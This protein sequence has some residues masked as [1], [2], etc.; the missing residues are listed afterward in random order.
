MMDLNYRKVFRVLFFLACLS[1][2]LWQCYL[3]MD[4]FLER[5]RST[6]VGFDHAKNWPMPRFVICPAIKDDVLRNCDSQPPSNDPT[7]NPNDPIVN[8]NDPT[9]NPNDPTVNP[10]DSTV[11]PN[12]PTGNPNDSTG[13]PN[14][15]TGNPDYPTGNPD[16]PTGNPNNHMGM[17]N[18]E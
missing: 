11:D 15:S 14:D 10:N 17:M 9:V 12:D 1:F 3:L 13:N 8:P 2:V 6:S 7:V 4:K 18:M 16:Y 5:P